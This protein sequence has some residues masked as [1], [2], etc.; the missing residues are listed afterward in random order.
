MGL[1]L[2]QA[3]SQVFGIG[4]KSFSGS[5]E[6]RIDLISVLREDVII[7]AIKTA[8]GRNDSDQKYL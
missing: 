2:T 5:I 7:I 4:C 1:Y 8:G 3:E 6:T